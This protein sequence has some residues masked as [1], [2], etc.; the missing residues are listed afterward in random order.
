FQFQYFLFNPLDFSAV[1]SKML[2]IR[3]NHYDF[4]VFC[5]S[6][7]KS[8]RIFDPETDD[9]LKIN[10]DYKMNVIS[11]FLMTRH[12]LL[13]HQKSQDKHTRFVLVAARNENPMLPFEKCHLP[14]APADFNNLLKRGNRRIPNDKVAGYMRFGLIAVGRYINGLSNPPH[15][16]NVSAITIY[17]Y[18]QNDNGSMLNIPFSICARLNMCSP[19]KKQVMKDSGTES[20]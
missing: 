20:R 3:K 10:V 11:H 8:D 18:T 15:S 14:D 9:K 7:S 16:L 5:A 17:P 4:V 1:W 13:S 6:G 12:L 2:E 19:S